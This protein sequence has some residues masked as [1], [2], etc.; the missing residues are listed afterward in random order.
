M[1][2]AMGAATTMAMSGGLVDSQV[3][4]WEDVNGISTD[5]LSEDEEKTIKCHFLFHGSNFVFLRVLLYI[6]SL[7]SLS[8]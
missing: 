4:N 2:M 6:L 8:R 7:M 5:S 3:P 1:I